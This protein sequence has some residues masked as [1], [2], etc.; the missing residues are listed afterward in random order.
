MVSDGYAFLVEML[1]EAKRRGFRIGE[2]PIIF[3]ERRIGQSKL[4]S[5][6]LLES[7]IMPWRLR[8]SAAAS[9]TCAH[10]V[11]MVTTSYPAV[12]GRQRRHLH[13]ADRRS[14][15]RRAATRST[16]SRR[17]TRAITRGKSEDGV[18]FHFFKYAPVPALNVFGYAAGAARRRAAARRGV[19]GRAAGA[20]G[21]LV[22]GAARRAEAARD[23]HAR[24]LGRPG[25]R[26]RRA[27]RGPRCRWSS[28]C[29]DRTSSSPSARRRRGAAARRVFE[30]A[31]VVTACSADLAQRA[32]SRSAPTADRIEVVPYG[33]DAARFRPRAGRAR[34]RCARGS[35]LAAGAPLR[36]HRRTAGPEEGLRVPDRRAAAARRA[37][38]AAHLAI[39][40][41]G[42]L[43][44]E[45]RAR[46]RAAGVADRVR[47]LG[48]LPQD[49]VARLV[50]RGRRRGRA[51]GPRRQRQRRRPAEHRARGARVGHA[52]RRDAGRRHRHAWSTT[53]DRAARPGARPARRSRR[54]SRRCWRDPALRAAL[55]APAGRAVRGAIRLGRASPSGS[56]RPTTAPLPS[57]QLGR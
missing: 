51:V 5:S 56:R 18:L 30:R 25:R 42:D 54:R 23:G 34:T 20:G 24:P 29:T 49:D 21:R 44:A 3:V 40:G 10:V 43:A 31:G 19:D 8:A 32:R 37:P 28:A 46:A 53:A 7:L 27:P 11:V 6:V 9:L 12:S 50:R 26:D 36:L 17:G 1:F 13:G 22:Q 55:G 45:L 41:D 33:V 39:A 14:A 4:S 38:T 57:T 35:A 16:S 47:F 48:D 2:V 52:G 15:S